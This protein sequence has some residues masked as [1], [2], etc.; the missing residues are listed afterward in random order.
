M[1]NGIMTGGPGPAIRI[2]PIPGFPDYFADEL[3]SIWSCRTVMGTTGTHLKE[4][5][6]KK[7]RGYRVV[8]LM[9]KPRTKKYMS[10]HRLVLLAF[11]GEP[12]TPRHQGAHADDDP[13]NN[14]LDNLSWKTPK[15][16]IAESTE[17]GRRCIG[18]R[19][20]HAKLSAEAVADIRSSFVPYKM[21]YRKLAEKYG[22]THRVIYLVLFGHSYRD[23]SLETV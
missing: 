17:R 4:I 22:V 1:S 21:T 23:V 12:P 13:G 5:I 18:T 20:P 9:P 3:G 8:L 19:S 11:V 2:K 16:N 10:V 7:I 14:R 6:G 15:Q